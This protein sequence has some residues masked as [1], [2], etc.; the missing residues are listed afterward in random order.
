M[1]LIVRG[2]PGIGKTAAIRAV[3]HEMDIDLHECGNDYNQ[4]KY[5][6]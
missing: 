2:R 3:A 4:T 1:A 6:K 5:L